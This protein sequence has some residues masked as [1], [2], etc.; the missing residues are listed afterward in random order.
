M[1]HWGADDTREAFGSF[2]PMHCLAAGTLGRHKGAG[3]SWLPFGG[4]ILPCTCQGEGEGGQWSAWLK[5]VMLERCC[6][7]PHLSAL[8]CMPAEVAPNPSEA[9]FAQL[10]IK[11]ERTKGLAPF[12]NFRSF[13]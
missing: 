2:L 13:H 6:P 9:T 10:R 7:V 1:Q 3:S 11:S 12:P 5:V 4:L 8:E